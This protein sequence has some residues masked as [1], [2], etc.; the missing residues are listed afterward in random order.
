MRL[1]PT[2]QLGAR[3]SAHVRGPRRSAPGLAVLIA[4]L[5]ASLSVPLTAG[6]E[7]K[8]KEPV[9]ADPSEPVFTPRPV[10]TMLWTGL[11]TSGVGAALLVVAGTSVSRV[12]QLQ[13]DEG[14]AAY[15]AGFTSDK[16]A[17]EQAEA[18]VVVDGA[19]SPGDA[20]D[21]CG[22]ASSWEIAGYVTAPSGLVLVG[23]GLYLI[24]TSDTVDEEAAIQVA[25]S[26]AE[27][28]ASVIVTGRF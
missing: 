5:V 9:S 2:R 8:P 17:C 1:I 10:D 11:G 6:A 20:A 22:E 19:M 21:L 18:G 7:P 14:F 26:V 27:D 25:P 24:L 23:L 13:D 12:R 28:G 15:R 3:A 16:D 4:T